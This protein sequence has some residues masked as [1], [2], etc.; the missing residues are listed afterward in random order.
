M[1]ACRPGKPSGIRG[2]GF[3]HLASL[4]LQN[5]RNYSSLSLEFPPSGAALVG[6]NGAGKTNLLEAI[7]LLCTGR[8]QRAASRKTMIRRGS[9]TA[10][11]QGE[12]RSAGRVPTS[13]QFGFSSDKKLSVKVNQQ[14]A[15][16]VSDWFGQHR[17][18]PFGPPDLQLVQG[19][20][21][22]RRRF[23]NMLL[24]QVNGGYLSDLILYRKALA[25]RN[26]LLSQGGTD[27]EI[28]T[29]EDR[30]A[31]HGARLTAGRRALFRSITGW[32]VEFYRQTR[33]ASDTGSASIRL[34][35]SIGAEED[36]ED[37]CRKVLAEALRGRRRK[38][39]MLGFSTAGPHRDDFLCAVEQGRA[40]SYASQGQC[41]TLAICLRLCSLRFLQHHGA[42]Q[43]FLVLVDDAFC[44]LDADRV[45]RIYPMI[46]GTGQLFITSTSP[47]LP[48]ANGLARMAVAGG[49]VRAV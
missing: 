32:F 44:E 27:S 19:P 49:A 30:M 16:S 45:S 1:D 37:A 34:T 23:M 26:A 24:S 46:K 41:R 31:E 25:Q 33:S 15:G 10:C 48:H 8:S 2:T 40:A 38:D 17:V 12:F 29:Y 9:D 39:R 47:D 5:F 13:V 7:Y 28:E 3:V 20:P 36:N 35:P 4:S 14:T 21:V 11:T 6:E 43:G 22:E 42:K 18:V